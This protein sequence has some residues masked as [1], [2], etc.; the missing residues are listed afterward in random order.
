[1][2]SFA[3]KVILV[4]GANG[5][6]G[7]HLVKRLSTIEGVKLLLLSRQKTQP[8]HDNQ[9][10]L[11]C[12]L[13]EL[14][15]E[16]MSSQGAKHVDYVFHL[17][18]FIPKIS[19]D[20]N[21]IEGALQDNIFGTSNLLNSL[22]N[23]PDK[24]VFSSTID[25][26]APSGVDEVLT[27]DS[28]VSPSNLYGASKYFCEQLISAWAEENN[29]KLSILRYGH[30]YGPGE[31]QYS[32]LIPEVIR[33]LLSGGSPTI[34]GD[35]SVLKDF[36]YVKD[37]VEAT[38]RA[39]LI[40]VSANVVNIVCGESVTVKEVVEMLVLSVGKNIKI[41]YLFEQKNGISQL[42]DNSRMNSV[43]GAFSMTSLEK[44]LADEVLYFINMNNSGS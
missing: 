10:W 37:A 7:R 15:P 12:D 21:N 9:I 3:G 16:Y 14:T 41:R 6:I 23:R 25:V 27:E 43:L 44:G 35:G 13:S 26:Y 42:F 1:M 2:N 33:T 40:D 8:Q 30:I 22:P 19:S 29:C 11:Q 31:E 34:Y 18:A 20:I 17:G 28:R 4:T 36:L 32:K 24:F 39:A 38:V 5:F